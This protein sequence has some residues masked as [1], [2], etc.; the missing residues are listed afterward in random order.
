MEDT[1]VGGEEDNSKQNKDGYILLLFIQHYLSSAL[2][3]DTGKTTTHH[4]A[5]HPRGGLVVP[6]Q[7][8]NVPVI[9]HLGH[10]W[11]CEVVLHGCGPSHGD[12]Q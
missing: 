5:Q 8:P 2:R 7:L 9:P 1:V 12:R 10:M 3:E 6:R 4:V 11:G